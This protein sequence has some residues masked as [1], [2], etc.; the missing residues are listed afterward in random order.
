MITRPYQWRSLGGKGGATASPNDK[1][2]LC[3]RN[4]E[5]SNEIDTLVGS[6]ETA[7]ATALFCLEKG[8]SLYQKG[9]FPDVQRVWSKNFPGRSTPS[10]HLS[11]F[12]PNGISMLSMTGGYRSTTPS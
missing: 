7:S 11:F 3:S 10:P 9:H 4:A 1:K 5:I 12:V 8:L 2:S 6:F